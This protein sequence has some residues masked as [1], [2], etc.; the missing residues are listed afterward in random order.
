MRQAL[1]Q[2]LRRA[3]HSHQPEEE[4]GKPCHLRR[5]RQALFQRYLLLISQ[6]LSLHWLK[7]NRDVLEAV[8]QLPVLPGRSSF[9]VS[10]HFPKTQ[11]IAFSYTAGGKKIKIRTFTPHRIKLRILSLDSKRKSLGIHQQALYTWETRLSAYSV[12]YK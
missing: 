8:S 7:Y 1:G 6:C 11:E 9:S 2:R 3:L 5:K 10:Y 12:Q 4:P